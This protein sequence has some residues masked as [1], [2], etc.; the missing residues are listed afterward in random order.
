[1]LFRV[2]ISILG[3]I[4]F[5]FRGI[6]GPP[7]DVKKV[8]YLLW[9]G[10]GNTV[11]AIPAIRALYGKYGKGLTVYAIN[12]HAGELLFPVRVVVAPALSIFGFLDT[13]KSIYNVHPEAV[14]TNF[15]S[16]SFLCSLLS[17]VSGARYRIGYNK[18][19]RGILFNVALQKERASERQ[20]NIN[21]IKDVF[22]LKVSRKVPIPKC[23]GFGE[24]FLE[25]IKGKILG[26]HP[27]GGFKSWGVERYK[28][29]IDS[30]SDVTVVLV[31][32]KQDEDVINRID[33][34]K[35]IY[36]Y[37]GEDIL[38]TA[39]L[40]SRFSLF[41]SGDTGLM[42]IASAVGV[43]VV[44]IFGPTDPL[45]NRPDGNVKLIRRQIPCSP[46]YRYK[47]PGCKKKI[48]LDIP[49]S[50]VLEVVKSVLKGYEKI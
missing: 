29:L 7:F 48:C 30:L 31:G 25:G 34:K 16:P 49:V 19:A 3:V 35:K 42:H 46:C 6:K 47:K 32:G 45:K 13:A 44:A 18:M 10:I 14:V 38:K 27:G 17:Y 36:R 37:I 1:M 12:P 21:V 50:D 5:P 43:P 41:L 39:N 4:L 33:T 9:G 8:L 23:D 2:I 40:I 22:S 20:A 26:I 28:E 15:S 11:M 24:Q